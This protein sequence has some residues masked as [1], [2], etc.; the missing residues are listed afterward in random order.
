MQGDFRSYLFGSEQ[1]REGGW[2]NLFVSQVKERCLLHIHF[3][4]VNPGLQVMALKADVTSRF[5]CGDLSIQVP[6]C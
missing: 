4:N 5:G 1:Q 2:K 6:N 3:N